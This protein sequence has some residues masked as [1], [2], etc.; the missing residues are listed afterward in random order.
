VGDLKKTFRIFKSLHVA[1][2]FC[3][4]MF[5]AKVA[6]GFGFNAFFLNIVAI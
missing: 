5:V 3:A 4:L 2:Y 1:C 6:V